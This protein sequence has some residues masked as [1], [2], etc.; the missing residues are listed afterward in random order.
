MKL[1]KKALGLTLCLIFLIWNPERVKAARFW[2]PI[3]GTKYKAEKDLR[4]DLSGT[5]IVD[6]CSVLTPNQIKLSNLFIIVSKNF[7]VNGMSLLDACYVVY[8]LRDG[9]FS[10][11]ALALELTIKEDDKV[12][13]NR[14]EICKEVLRVAKDDPDIKDLVHEAHPDNLHNILEKVESVIK[15]GMEDLGGEACSKL[16]QEEISIANALVIILLE[17]GYKI[18]RTRACTVLLSLK[19]GSL[20]DCAKS[21]RSAL[22]GHIEYTQAERFCQEMAGFASKKYP[23]I[24]GKLNNGHIFPIDGVNSNL[25]NKVEANEAILV[26]LAIDNRCHLDE[27]DVRQIL[28]TN[29]P[30]TNVVVD[31]RQ[32][33]DRF[34][35]FYNRNKSGKIAKRWFKDG[36]LNGV[37]EEESNTPLG[38]KMELVNLTNQQAL[39]TLYSTYRSLIGSFKETQKFVQDIQYQRGSIPQSLKRRFYMQIQ[40]VK[41]MEKHIGALKEYIESDN[42]DIYSASNLPYGIS[43]LRSFSEL[44]RKDW[45][46]SF[47]EDKPYEEM[48]RFSLFCSILHKSAF[49]LALLVVGV[50]HSILGKTKIKLPDA[51]LAISQVKNDRDHK[52][53]IKL[54]LSLVFVNNQ[55]ILNLDELETLYNLLVASVDESIN[56]FLLGI[57][58]EFFNFDDERDITDEKLERWIAKVEH[59]LTKVIIEPKSI[60]NNIS[61]FDVDMIMQSISPLEAKLQ[62]LIG[63]SLRRIHEALEDL[64]D[65]EHEMRKLTNKIEFARIQ[66]DS[67]SEITDTQEY[68]LLS[69]KREENLQKVIDLG[70]EHA[71]YCAKAIDIFDISDR[72]IVRKVHRII[73]IN[74]ELRRLTISYSKAQQDKPIFKSNKV[75]LRTSIINHRR[76]LAKKM[77]EELIIGEAYNPSDNRWYTDLNDCFNNFVPDLKLSLKLDP[78]HIVERSSGFSKI[79]PKKK[80][81]KYNLLCDKNQLRR[82][83][84]FQPD[85]EKIFKLAEIPVIDFEGNRPLM[86]DILTLE[87]W[88]PLKTTIHEKEEPN[89]PCSIAKQLFRKIVSDISQRATGGTSFFNIPLVHLWCA[90][91]IRFRRGNQAIWRNLIPRI[92]S[93]FIEEPLDISKLRSNKWTISNWFR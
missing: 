23:N 59:R 18:S 32:L 15:M 83:K 46:H 19:E 11:C 27:L 60:L 43:D 13:D 48:N 2:R 20:E 42:T 25:K 91:H 52:N 61:L 92:W 1:L 24:S 29:Y 85:L 4:E 77:L 5:L 75:L 35:I 31:R 89:I 37:E 79:N 63:V 56:E 50:S 67:S 55:K 6:Y 69:K 88:A 93:I 40:F 38:P 28:F 16:S 78:S 22:R 58:E 8:V 81:P 33:F 62:L 10:A 76:N 45:T 12:K 82:F 80:P 7:S 26:A 17:E 41:Y 21:L 73:A 87:G 3:F 57:P 74:T 30:S 34:L 14:L 9:Y 86:A 54:A 90:D 64:T 68:N 84:I 39:Q 49:R 44:A 65:I 71:G 51:C 66:T 53:S 36:V 72:P 47:V 70:V